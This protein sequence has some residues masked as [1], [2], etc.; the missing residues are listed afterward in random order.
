MTECDLKDEKCGGACTG[1]DGSKIWAE[2]MAQIKDPKKYD[3]ETCQEEA[4]NLEIFNHDIVNAKLGKPIF[5][6]TNF[7]KEA[8]AIKCI[9]DNNPGLC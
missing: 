7:K 8:Q 3:C 6:K 2:R 5:N 1:F 9:C 4:E